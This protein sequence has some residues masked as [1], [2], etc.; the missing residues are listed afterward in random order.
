MYFII[1]LFGYKNYLSSHHHINSSCWFCV[2]INFYINVSFFHFDWFLAIIYWRTDTYMKSVGI[3]FLS[4]YY[5][6]NQAS[7]FHVAMHLFSHRSQKTSKCGKNINDKLSLCLYSYHIW[8]HL[9]INTEQTHRN[10]ESIYYKWRRILACLTYLQD[11]FHLI[12]IV[13]IRNKNI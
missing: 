10:M 11:V 7:R 3:F 9:W 1:C 12:W 2:L 6:I 4:L 13:W 8:H 5:I